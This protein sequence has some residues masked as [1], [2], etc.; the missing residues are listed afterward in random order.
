MEGRFYEK[1]PKSKLAT[2]ATFQNRMEYGVFNRINR[3]NRVGILLYR[4]VVFLE[5]A[6]KKSRHGKVF[7]ARE[8]NLPVYS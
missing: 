6:G 7:Q 8:L 3:P 5:K 2:Q 4:S 1:Y